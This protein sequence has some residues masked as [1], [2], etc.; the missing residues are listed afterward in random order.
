MYKK[1]IALLLTLCLILSAAPIYIGAAGIATVSAPDVTV[2]KG[3]SVCVNITAEDFQNVASLDLFIYY[4]ATAFNLYYT[5]NGNM[6]AGTQTSVNTSTA[7]AVKLSTISLDGMNGTDTL[8]Y[9]Y[10]ETLDAAEA[11]KYDVTVAVGDAYNTSLSPTSIRGNNGSILA[12]EAPQ[13]EV[14]SI[15]TYTEESDISK[16]DVISYRIISSSYSSFASA[17]FI[18]EYDYEVFEF[19][20]IELEEPLKNDGAI[21]SVNSQPL[22][23][24]RLSYASTVAVQTSYLFKVN[25]RCIANKNTDTTLKTHAQNIYREDL[26]PYVP[27]FHEYTLNVIKAPEV[28]DYPDLYLEVDKLIAGDTANAMLY[29]EKGAKIAAGDFSVSYDPEVF[30][31]ISVTPADGIS[32]I[33]GMIVINDNFD[34]GKI[35]FSYVNMEAYDKEN[36]ALINITLEPLKSPQEHYELLVSGVGVVDQSTSSAALEY[37]PNSG[38]I[39]EREVIPPG[40][41]TEGMTIYTCYCGE[42]YRED[43]LPSLGHDEV[44]HAAKAESCTENGWLEYVTCTRCDYSTYESIPFKGHSFNNGYCS[45]CLIKDPSWSETEEYIPGD[46]NG[47]GRVNSLDS[48]L[49]K[50]ALVGFVILSPQQEKSADVD[51]N[52]KINSMDSSLI[53]KI[54]SGDFKIQS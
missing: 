33:G 28:M 11:G 51:N 2:T 30:R 23:Q 4:D 7:G 16:D 18:I 39:F 44:H 43:I 32:S 36:V 20:S 27:S 15:Y 12:E 19:D 26:T 53:K 6:L 21:Y 5:E 25:L 47:D 50:K 35:R 24:V 54:I 31:I 14:F 48:N 37:I 8:L 3:G 49:I 52:G 9:L 13:S 10:F 29:I 17:D 34:E 45:I 42:S 41:E 38:C 40:C 1:I 22:G 46:L